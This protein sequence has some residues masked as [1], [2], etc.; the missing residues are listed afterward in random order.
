LAT[1]LGMPPPILDDLLW[2]RGRDDP[3]LIGTDA[4]EL[5]EPARDPGSHWY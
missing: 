2:E 4:G 5:Q 1:S 3:D